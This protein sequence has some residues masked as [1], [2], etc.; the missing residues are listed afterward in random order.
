MRTLAHGLSLVVLTGL[1]AMPGSAQVAGINPHGPL[2][3]DL[4]CVSCHTPESW[5]PVKSS[6][7]F[8]HARTAFPLTGTHAEAQCTRCHMDLRFDQPR[9][10]LADCASCHLDVHQ[11]ALGQ[12]CASCHSTAS[13]QQVE[14][15]QLHARTEFPLSGAHLQVTC[16][17]C[18]TDDRGGAFSTRDSDCLSCHVADYQ[19]TDVVDHERLGFPTSCQ[20]CHGTL[21]WRASESFDHARLS[22]GFGLVGAHVGLECARCHQMP[23]LEPLWR[24]ADQDDC[25]TCHVADFDREHGGQGFPTTCLSC[26][27]VDSWDGAGLDHPTLSEGFRLIGR[28]QD[29]ACSSCHSGPAFDVPFQAADDQDCVACHRTDYDREHSGGGFPTG[30]VQCHSETGWEGA[31]FDHLQVTGFPL[32]GEHAEAPCAGCHLIPSTELRFTPRD[33]DDCVACH[34]ADYEGEHA[35]TNI[36]TECATCHT[37]DGWGTATFDHLALSEGFALV[38]R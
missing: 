28:H 22:D 31:A 29:A 12:D 6:P 15:V 8:D 3:A 34:Q 1:L 36:P 27:G 20:Q 26:H 21:S 32:L 25:V 9:V 30:C 35:G 18:H 10:P 17:T 5:T 19:R 11:A 4:D 16:E 33:V 13:F 7:D 14:A 23:S 2:P 37:V 24:P 38:G